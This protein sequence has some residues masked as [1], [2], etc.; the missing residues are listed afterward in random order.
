MK[1]EQPLADKWQRLLNQI[2][3]YSSAIVAFSGGVDSSLLAYTAHLVLG[4]KMLAVTVDSGFDSQTQ[5]TQAEAFTLQ[6]GIP[7]KKLSIPLFN[8]EKII[9]NPPER[10]YYCKLTILTALRDYARQN[11]FAVVLEGQNA[12]DL[13]V[14]RPGRRAVQETETYSPLLEQQL[15]KTEIRQ[16]ART[17]GLAVWEA[18][19]SPCLATRVP[20]YTPITQKVLRQ[21]EEAEV[22]LKGKGFTHVRV[23]Y[24]Q[25]LARIEVAPQEIDALTDARFDIVQKFHELGFQYITV[26]LEGYRSGSMDEGVTR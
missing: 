1:L 25:Q 15:T 19:S 13:L 12:D 18:E 22:Y 16:I 4:E 9:S 21:I 5:F 2:G 3:E 7:W 10:C 26:D 23:R 11:H 17:L 8:N 14:H 20:Y 24:H 6:Y